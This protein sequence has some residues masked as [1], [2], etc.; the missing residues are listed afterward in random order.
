MIQFLML[1]HIV[2]LIL[3]I[4][5]DRRTGVNRLRSLVLPVGFSFVYTSV[6]QA[7]AAV[8]NLGYGLNQNDIA[9]ALWASLMSY[10]AILLAYRY[11]PDNGRRSSFA[12]RNVVPAR[13]NSFGLFFFVA[14]LIGYYLSMQ[15][16][17]GWRA[18][19]NMEDWTGNLYDISAY[20]Y[21]LKYA[22]Y[23]AVALWLL[24]LSLRALPTWFHGLLI[25]LMLWLLFEAVQLTD[26]GD[27]IRA[28]LPIV[29]WFY[30]VTH[31]YRH[32]IEYRLLGNLVIASML[33]FV[34]LAGILLPEFRD[35]DRSMMRSDTTL[36]VAFERSRAKNASS[37]ASEGGGE[38]DT[39]ARII[40]RVNAGEISPPGPVHIGRLIWNIVPRA[41]V[42]NKHEIYEA[43][44]GKNYME[45]RYGC[46]SYMGC[47]STGWGEAYGMMGWFGAILYWALFGFGIRRFENWI[48]ESSLGLIVSAICYLPLIQF[49]IQDFWAGG[50]NTSIVVLP[51]LIMIKL[52]QRKGVIKGNSLK[53]TRMVRQKKELD[54]LDLA[55]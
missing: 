17:G 4:I 54:V 6:V 16:V 29:A 43:W 45:V 5:M 30:I 39:G 26:R 46:I 31:R 23:A 35:A 34:S 13:L 28:S 41:L 18:L 52:C 9:T 12:R 11:A 24:S 37:R 14:G 50:M 7:G 21:M 44:A 1:A 2:L 19:L 33:L 38:F 22:C 15:A 53:K 48:G 8:Q 47:S 55:H 36:A 32:R 42:P 25:L 51:V 27:T 10:L 20:I 49:V 40:K 3:S